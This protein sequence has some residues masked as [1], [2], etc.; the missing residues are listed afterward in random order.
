MV[1]DIFK[2]LEQFIVIDLNN[3]KKTKYI[4]ED[5]YTVS[6]N[7][8]LKKSLLEYG[9]DL[10]K[11]SQNPIKFCNEQLGWENTNSEIYE[12]IFHEG[13]LY[14]V[15]KQDLDI[16][17]ELFDKDSDN[18]LNTDMLSNPVDCDDYLSYEE[19]DT[20]CNLSYNYF[21]N[22]ESVFEKYFF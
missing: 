3:L 20:R 7:K 16:L 18:Y 13:K 15:Y 2:E 12:I 22:A 9:K 19:S 4:N 1:K 5:L 14:L 17:H 21:K 8:E 6:R 11:F 10:L